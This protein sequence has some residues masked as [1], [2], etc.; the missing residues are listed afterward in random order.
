MSLRPVVEQNLSQA[1][2]QEAAAV[3]A[4]QKRLLLRCFRYSSE[5][6]VYGLADPMVVLFPSPSGSAPYSVACFPFF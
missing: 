1:D 5:V 6:T 3:E 4:L 2:G